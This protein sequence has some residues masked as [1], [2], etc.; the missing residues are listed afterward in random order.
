MRWTQMVA[1][2]IVVST[3]AACWAE[4]PEFSNNRPQGMQL[5]QGK[6]L[7]GQA[8][9][10]RYGEPVSYSAQAQAEASLSDKNGPAAPMPMYGDGGYVYGPGTCDCP[11]A[12]IGHLWAG[13]IQNF[14]RCHTHHLLNRHCGCNTCDTGCNTC[15]HCHPFLSRIFGHGCCDTNS[16]TSAV[17]CG[18]AVPTCAAPAP[19][20]A[21]PSCSATA[22]CGCKP[23]CGKCRHCHIGDKWRG[24]MAHWSCGCGCSSCSAPLSCG[25]ATPTYAAPTSEKQASNGP[26]VPVPEEAAIFPLSRLK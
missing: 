5:F 21:A 20:C 18:C 16:C 23:V 7:G 10:G 25:C 17:S 9:W 2:A 8:W 15:G 3:S 11:P 26:P 13:Y 19:S 14:K 24:F 4:T 22:D 12:C 1:A 6:L